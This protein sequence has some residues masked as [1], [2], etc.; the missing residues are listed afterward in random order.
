MFDFINFTGS[1]N[2]EL[3]I[4]LA[5]GG[6]LLASVRNLVEKTRLCYGRCKY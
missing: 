5:A 4:E 1:V 3:T 6:S 2:A